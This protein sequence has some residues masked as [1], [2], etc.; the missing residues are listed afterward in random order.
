[1]AATTIARRAGLRF[2]AWRAE[3]VVV[4]IAALLLGYLTVVP[5]GMLLLGSVSAGSSALDFQ[6]TLRNFQRVITDQASLELL[7]NSVMY[8]LGSSVLAFSIGTA[9]AWAVERSDIPGRNLW[10]GLALVPLIIPGIVHTIAWLFLLSPE[11]GWINA[12]LKAFFGFS[13][14]VYSLPGMIWI[15]ALH[16]APLGFVLMSSA[17]RAMDPSL[18]EAAA[19]SRANTWRTLRRVTLPLLLPTAA[20]VLL[21]L[22]VRAI[23]G[24]EVPAIIGLPGGIYVYT[25][26]IYTSLNQ[27]PP[28]FG[29]SASYAIVLLVISVGALLLHNRVTRRTERYATV[30]GKA[31]R[32]RRVELGRFRFVAVGA[33]SLYALIAIGLPLLVLIYASLV[34]VYTVPSIETM[35]ELTLGNYAYIWND[36]LTRRAFGNSLMLG[37]AAATIVVGLTAVIAW[38]TIRT[39]VPGRGVLDFLAFIPI[40][41]PGIVLGISL[42]WVYFTVPIRIYGTLWILLVAYVTRY[43]PYGIRSASASIVQIHRELEEAASAAGAR[44]WPT[45]RRILLPLLRPALVGAW[46]YVFIISLRELGS[47]VLLYSSQS[48]VLAVRIF[49]L[50]DSGNYTTI[51]ALSIVMILMLV[52]LVTILQRV[53]GRAVGEH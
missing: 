30:T 11:I 18:E 19:T 3:V 16:T 28:N 12:P 15:E 35:R 7:A 10:Y 38:V 23:E 22:F 50:R 41:I 36:E 5:L 51:A 21:I 49:D 1:M 13:M 48:V 20:S 4:G 53:G 52:L 47:S 8:G 25:S 26:R 40:T 39:R 17:F 2:P 46:I 27:Y 33:L 29:L 45:F 34:R 24:F 9:V 43:L 44:W 37:A 14:S 32:P 42:I 31:Y 6:F